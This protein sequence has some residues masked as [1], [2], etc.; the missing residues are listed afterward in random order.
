M[1]R[2]FPEEEIMKKKH[3]SKLVHEGS[4]IAE[5]DVELIE[6]EG[7]WSPYLSPDDAYRLDD[8]AMLSAGAISRRR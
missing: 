2:G 4:Y 6:L 8:V 3:R 7:G 1:D 5:V